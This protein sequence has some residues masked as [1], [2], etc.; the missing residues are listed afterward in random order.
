MKQYIRYYAHTDV[1][2]VGDLTY[3]E[4][5]IHRLDAINGIDI[6]GLT[7]VP[8]P[9]F[10]GVDG[11]AL[12]NS[13]TGRIFAL[14]ENTNA[15]PAD[16]LTISIA[17][18]TTVTEGQGT[19]AVADVEIVIGDGEKALIGPFSANFNAANRVVFLFAGAGTL[20]KEDI[21]INFFKLS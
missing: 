7:P 21:I 9:V 8:C 12:Y 14:I 13:P 10:A 6:D 18:T 2:K 11:I 16:D 3:D 1:G 4:T 17:S 20:A 19:L 15:T 5:Y